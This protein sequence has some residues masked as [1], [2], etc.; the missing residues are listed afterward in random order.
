[1]ALNNAQKHKVKVSETTFGL[2]VLEDNVSG[3]KCFRC[4]F[5]M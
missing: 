4:K 3:K 5:I 1:M 2:L